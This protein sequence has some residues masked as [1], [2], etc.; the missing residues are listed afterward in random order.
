MDLKKKDTNN[1]WYLFI[2]RK[3][4]NTMFLKCVQNSGGGTDEPLNVPLAQCHNFPAIK[5]LGLNEL[6]L[7]DNSTSNSYILSSQYDLR[8][9]GAK[10][11]SVDIDYDLADAGSI[12]FIKSN[13]SIFTTDVNTFIA[14]NVFLSGTRIDI[15]GANGA[16][17]GKIQGDFDISD[18]QTLMFIM[19]SGKHPDILQT[20]LNDWVNSARG[21]YHFKVNKFII[22]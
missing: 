18:A 2:S 15:K 22:T 11:L 20:G 7:E 9:L 21:N 6:T 5:V 3:G 16:S 1:R 14:S 4:D 17:Q 19:F 12:G 10:K 13:Q 8:N